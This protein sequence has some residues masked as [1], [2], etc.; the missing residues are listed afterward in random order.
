MFPNDPIYLFNKIIQTSKRKKE[1]EAINTPNSPFRVETG[2]VLFEV[3]V[4]TSEDAES[5]LKEVCDEAARG[6]LEAELG[7]AAPSPSRRPRR[8]YKSLPSLA[9]APSPPPPLGA[10]VSPSH[11]S[12]A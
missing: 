8:M 1:K 2:L 9:S 5:E 7:G 4:L 12:S 6:V 10:S 3:V 11:S